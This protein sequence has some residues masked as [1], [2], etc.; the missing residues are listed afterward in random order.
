MFFC[1]SELFDYT[2]TLETANE[3]SVYVKFRIVEEGPKAI[4]TVPYDSR[5]ASPVYEI[6][7]NQKKRSIIAYGRIEIPKLSSTTE[8]SVEL[9]RRIELFEVASDEMCGQLAVGIRIGVLHLDLE[10]DQVGNNA[11]SIGNDNN[12]I[13]QPQAVR[14]NADN[15]NNLLSVNR[16]YSASTVSEHAC[17]S[18]VVLNELDVEGVEA[19]KAEVVKLSDNVVTTA[20]GNLSLIAERSATAS[21]TP[22]VKSVKSYSSSRSSLAEE[23]DFEDEIELTEQ[24]EKSTKNYLTFDTVGSSMTRSTST[25][26][27][28]NQVS[29]DKYSD[30]VGLLSLEIVAAQNL[31]KEK[32]LLRSTH[33]DSN[34][35][36]TISFGKKSFR[37]KVQRN[38]ANPVW[39][40]KLAFSVKA[41]EMNY[42]VMFS[43]YDYETIGYN[44]CL[45]TANI[46][47]GH[48]LQNPEQTLKLA[49]PLNP[50]K[51][52]I[53]SFIFV[54]IFTRF[55]FVLFG[56]GF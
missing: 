51:T 14:C 35:F 6:V 27:V 39:R 38:A 12:V 18:N 47:I 31:P 20:D 30:I 23:S 21:P 49:V 37:T 19:T 26:S 10:K 34:P 43:V 54:T 22:S 7:P 1:Y 8:D 50:S 46:R 15:S 9:F 48:F 17:E 36:V 52:V 3:N 25:S 53:L 13:F 40:E 45:A 42:Q 56:L 4:L 41:S 32:R 2:E 24:M 44:S 33:Y 11:I 55:C 28:T 29:G 5:S 16:M